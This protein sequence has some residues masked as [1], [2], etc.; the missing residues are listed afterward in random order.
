MSNAPEYT[1]PV[2]LQDVR[3]LVLGGGGFIGTNLC[4]ALMA[5]G[6]IVHGFGRR[7]SYPEA[8]RGMLWTQGDFSDRDAL[9]R[10]VDGHDVIFHLVGGSLLPM[11]RNPLLAVQGPDQ[12]RVS[13]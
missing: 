8:L 2:A 6:A 11:D 4:H 7:Q 3:C 13:V 12:D 10:T 1:E 5:R 9:A